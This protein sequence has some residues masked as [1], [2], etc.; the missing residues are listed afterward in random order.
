MRNILV[1]YQKCHQN[2]T[3]EIKT[4]FIGDEYVDYGLMI[5]FLASV[6]GGA[7]GLDTLWVESQTI[8]FSFLNDTITIFQG[9]ILRIQFAI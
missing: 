9:N 7:T 4:N 8:L 3:I 6:P 5:A 2:V 1:P